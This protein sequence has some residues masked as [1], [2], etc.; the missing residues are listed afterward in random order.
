MINIKYYCLII[1]NY[2]CQQLQSIINST[3]NSC[4]LKLPWMLPHF[5]INK[6]RW[7]S[8]QPITALHMYIQ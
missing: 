5:P 1:I 3:L 6:T 2:W 8:R 4:G 7:K